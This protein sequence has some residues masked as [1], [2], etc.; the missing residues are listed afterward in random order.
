MHKINLI[1]K[2]G[3]DVIVQKYK[4]VIIYRHINNHTGDLRLGHS[5][6]FWF[7]YPNF[8]YCTGFFHSNNTIHRENPILIISGTCGPQF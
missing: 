6:R 2:K 4:T 7:L 5:L 8:H 1:N 3:L